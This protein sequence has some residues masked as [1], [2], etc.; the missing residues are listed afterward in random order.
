M[1]DTSL[2][3]FTPQYPQLSDDQLLSQAKS[4]D[5]QAFS[6][7]CLRYKTMLKQKIFRIVQHAEDTEDVLQ[8]TF[9]N[10]YTH[11][12]AF[13]EACKFSTWLIK[14]AMNVSLMLLRKRRKLS[15]IDPNEITEDGQSFRAWE[16]RDPRPDPEQNYITGQTRL[17]LRKAI[18][19]LPP[20]ARSVMDLYFRQQRHLKE[21]A[22]TLGITESAAKSRILRA[23]RVLFRS[24]RRQWDPE[25]AAITSRNYQ[26]PPG[27]LFADGNAVV[28]T[29]T[30]C[31]DVNR[32]G[33]LIQTE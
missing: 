21:T 18:E 8:D 6:E 16:F 1:K 12:H 29:T 19:R 7:L 3:H 22:A 20:A 32:S 4:G 26:R 25:G 2:E 17:T 23:R 10:A 14:I 5:Q 13:R 31:P 24:M 15:E 11:L 27:H 28:R 30:V 33:E 9:L